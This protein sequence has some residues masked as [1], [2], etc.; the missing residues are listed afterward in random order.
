MKKTIL[1]GMMAVALVSLMAVNVYAC[2]GPGLSP[3][4]WKHNLGVYL[5]EANG[6]YSDPGVTA[7]RIAEMGNPAGPSQA[8]TKDN[9]A[10]WFAQLAGAPWNL[11][12]E[13]LYEDLCTKGGGAAGAATRVGAANVFNYWADLYPYED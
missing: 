7:I 13:Q 11:D 4:F 12:L 2:V 1:V 9:M 3:G 8:V 10:W 6:K 5:G